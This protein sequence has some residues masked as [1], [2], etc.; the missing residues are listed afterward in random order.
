MFKRVIWFGVGVT[1]GA[2]GTVWTERKVRQQLDRARP[3]AMVESVQQA[4]REA[5]AEGRTAAKAREAELRGRIAS[6]S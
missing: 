2:V 4:V 3:A 6:R 5:V 1:A